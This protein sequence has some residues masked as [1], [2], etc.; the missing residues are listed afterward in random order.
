MLSCLLSHVG[1]LPAYSEWTYVDTVNAM[2]GSG[3]DG[4]PCLVPFVDPHM[5]E[6]GLP[7]WFHTLGVQRSPHHFVFDRKNRWK[8]CTPTLPVSPD[9][10]YKNISSISDGSLFKA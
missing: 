5:A 4:S 2:K 8:S 7:F 10:E 9:T 3:N 1:R 6:R